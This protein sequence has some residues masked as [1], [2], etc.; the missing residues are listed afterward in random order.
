MQILIHGQKRF[1]DHKF[2]ECSKE[3]WLN[4]LEEY[5][6]GSIQRPVYLHENTFSSFQFSSVD[7]LSR[8]NKYFSVEKN[9]K[10]IGAVNVGEISSSVIRARNIFIKKE[11]RKLGIT[12][13]LLA[14]CIEQSLSRHKRIVSFSTEEALEFWISC[15]FQKNQQFTPRS[16]RPIRE[17][18]SVK[19][20][21]LLYYMEKSINHE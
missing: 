20:N 10:I 16:I 5:D 18:R 2:Q 14:F 8:F 17:D 9:G 21:E 13:K 4:L 7:L 6:H 11:F 19:N 12:K 3:V 15:G 1:M